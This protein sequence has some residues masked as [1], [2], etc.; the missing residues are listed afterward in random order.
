MR[1]HL[2]LSRREAYQLALRGRDIAERID[3]DLADLG[4][5]VIDTDPVWTSNLLALANW[6]KGE[7]VAA[8]V[9]GDH[10]ICE[11]LDTAAVA[12][13]GEHLARRH[14]EAADNARATAV[15]D[16]QPRVEHSAKNVDLSWLV[17]TDEY[18]L[19]ISGETWVLTQ[20][21]VEDLHEHLSKLM[22]D[23]SNRAE[24]ADEARSLAA[25]AEYYGC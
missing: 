23:V 2:N 19:T 22:D 12:V 7:S 5:G 24:A 14:V 1:H 15:A 17:G 3:L 25:I 18:E 13:R 9:N 21:Q 10:R 8:G 11:E 16:D 6:L 4:A 20:R